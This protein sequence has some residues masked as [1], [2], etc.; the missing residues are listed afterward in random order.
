[1]NQS[2]FP[3]WL[4]WMLVCFLIT[5]CHFIRK[6]LKSSFLLKLYTHVF[7]GFNEQFLK[8][9]TFFTNINC[10]RLKNE[11]WTT[12]LR[13]RQVW[14]SCPDFCSCTVPA[15]YF[16]WPNPLS[17]VDVCSVLYDSEFQ[18]KFLWTLVTDFWHYGVLSICQ[19]HWYV[20]LTLWVCHMPWL[21]CDS[22]TITMELF[23]FTFC[24][25]VRTSL[26]ELLG[27]HLYPG[28]H[29]SV[30]LWL[31]CGSCLPRVCF[32]F[33]CSFPYTEDLKANNEY[34]YVLWQFCFY[35]SLFTGRFNLL[36]GLV[37]QVCN[38]CYLWN[39]EGRNPKVKAC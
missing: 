11:T 3:L 5:W 24:V 18:N 31:P 20:R 7:N 16:V 4:P 32:Y 1:M 15:P 8:K 34:F 14:G 26:T 13:D 23:C 17:S 6:F 30:S 22:Q 38:P 19:C 37:A 36:P 9:K 29:L 33:Q 21:P 10:Y 35:A 39:W 25:S 27:K 12:S 28:R 2:P